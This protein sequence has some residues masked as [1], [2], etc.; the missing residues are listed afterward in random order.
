MKSANSIITNL[1]GGILIT[2][3]ILKGY[4][5]LTEPVAENSIWTSKLFL[6]ATVEMELFLGFWLL[7]NILRQALIEVPTYNHSQINP[8]SPC[9]LGRMDNSKEWFISTPSVA[10]LTNSNVKQAREEKTPD[11]ETIIESIAISVEKTTK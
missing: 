7:S 3:A 5:L 2:A 9:T 6:I 8:N 10:I 11:F 4:Q 1:L